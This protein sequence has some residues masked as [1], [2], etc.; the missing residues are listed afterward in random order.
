MMVFWDSQ[1][2]YLDLFSRT[3]HLKYPHTLIFFFFDSK[4]DACLFCLLLLLHLVTFFDML[5]H[6]FLD[7]SILDDFFEER[8]FAPHMAGTFSILCQT[9]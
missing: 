5:T 7:P 2:S 1:T 9:L 8:K 4:N 3:T 6:G